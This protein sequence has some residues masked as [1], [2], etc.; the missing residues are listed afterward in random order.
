MA[1][2]RY[3]NAQICSNGHIVNSSARSY[4]ERNSNF[5]PNCGAASLTTCSNCNAPIR[6]QY[7]PDGLALV[8]P[9]HPPSYC[10]N[11]GKAYPWTDSKIEALKELIELD[12]KNTDAEKAAL[13]ADLPDLVRDTARTQ[14]A[15]T[16]FQ[17]FLV[18][19]ASGT[20]SAIRDIVVDI[21]SEAAKKTIFGP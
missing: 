5:C 7:L 8:G 13:A 16:R 19:A 1:P 20:A 21:A 14:V 4:P 10:P 9:Y 6:G 3:D 18:K 11:C 17:K 15:A 2:G 12:D